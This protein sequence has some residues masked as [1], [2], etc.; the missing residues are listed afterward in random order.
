DHYA[1]SAQHVTDDIFAAPIPTFF[2][3]D[4]TFY[5]PLDGWNESNIRSFYDMSTTRSTSTKAGITH[6]RLSFRL[7]DPTPPP[8]WS[9]TH[10][11]CAYSTVV[12]TYPPS[13]QL[14]T[15]DLLCSRGKRSSPRCRDGCNDVKDMHHI[16]V[17]C[18]RYAEW[19]SK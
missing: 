4:F 6:Q 19:R 3:D 12:Q 16:F 1:S 13:G 8:D 15:A 10:G 17:I 7:H 18:P 14:P 5:T 9:Y 2:M 11:F